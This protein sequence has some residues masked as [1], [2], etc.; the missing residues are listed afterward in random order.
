MT[1]GPRMP[2]DRGDARACGRWVGNLRACRRHRARAD[3]SGVLAAAVAVGVLL[4][5]LRMAL[6]M[7]EVA[8]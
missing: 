4:A 3:G 5:V 8:G 7:L 6:S 1:F 2:R